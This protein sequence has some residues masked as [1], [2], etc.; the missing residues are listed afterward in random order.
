MTT[1]VHVLW[2]DD[3][4]RPIGIYRTYDLALKALGAREGLM[5]IE[6]FEVQG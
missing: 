5:R 2:S 6:K 3:A 1:T 4:E